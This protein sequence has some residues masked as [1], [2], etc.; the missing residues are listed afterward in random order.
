LKTAACSGAPQQQFLFHGAF[1]EVNNNCL[2]Y[3]GS[4]IVLQKCMRDHGINMPDP[5]PSGQMGMTIGG[6]DSD[7]DKMDK[8]MKDCGMNIGGGHVSVNGGGSADGGAS[9]DGGR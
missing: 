2:G 6:P 9:T 3:S 4:K 7:P 8:A 1:F 5:D